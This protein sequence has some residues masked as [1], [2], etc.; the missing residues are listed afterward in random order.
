VARWIKPGVALRTTSSN[1]IPARQLSNRALAK[2]IAK[3]GLAEGIPRGSGRRPV[4]ADRM[5][6][7][8]NR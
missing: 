2:L 3:Y 6:S 7:G 5:R 8:V 4:K 1:A